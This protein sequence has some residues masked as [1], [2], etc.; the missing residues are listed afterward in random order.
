MYAIQ[1]R[2]KGQKTWYYLTSK[3][4]GSRAKI[5]AGQIESKELAERVIA[6]NEGDNPEYE[7]RVVKL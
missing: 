2:I 7:F 3:G 6:E 1:Y 4:E 5:R